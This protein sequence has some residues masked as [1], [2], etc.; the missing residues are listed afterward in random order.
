MS[1]SSQQGDGKVK[2]S[3]KVPEVWMTNL[4]GAVARYGSHSAV[5]QEACVMWLAWVAPQIGS[6]RAELP[7]DQRLGVDEL[8]ALDWSLAHQVDV[9]IYSVPN[10]E[11]RF[12]GYIDAELKHVLDVLAQKYLLQDVLFTLLLYFIENDPAAW[13]EET[14]PNVC[15][16]YVRKE[17]A[18]QVRG[19]MQVGEFMRSRDLIEHAVEW[20][21][22]HY[23]VDP[24]A[25]YRA[26][27][28]LQ[29]VGPSADY[30]TITLTIDPVLHARVSRCARLDDQALRTVY[31]NI[32]QAYLD[33]HAA[34]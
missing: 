1:G 33:A 10:N 12:I 8:A 30:Q 23:N 15:V 4:E 14:S 26:R 13:R 20:W 5:L 19:L 28:H 29:F 7:E 11:K 18:E 6:P 16:V 21:L 17:R 22:E 34:C 31:F 32:L 3:C 24:F 25:F 9:L 27:P 2:V